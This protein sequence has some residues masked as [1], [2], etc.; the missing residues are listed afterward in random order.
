MENNINCILLDTVTLPLL[1]DCDILT[2]SDNFC[3][4]DRTADFNVLIYV[5]NGVMYVTEDEQDYEIAAEKCCSCAADFGITES[6]KL[7]AGHVGSM[8]IF[9]FPI[10]Q[11]TSSIS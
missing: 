11:Q 1:T 5:T 7:S 4:M 2:A 8:P 10:P 3:H 6:V 9:I